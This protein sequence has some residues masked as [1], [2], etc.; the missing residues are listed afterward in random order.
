MA[1]DEPAQYPHDLGRAAISITFGDQAENGP[2]MQKL[3][4]PAPAGLA[5]EDLRRAQAAF[6]A[7]GARCEL[8]DLVAAGRVEEFGGDAGPEPAFLLV[9][10]GGVDAL[11]GPLGT[12]GLLSEQRSLPGRG[13]PP[14]MK[15]I[16]RGAVKTKRAR[17]NLCFWDSRQAPDYP[18]GKGRVVAFE[19]VPELARVRARLAEVFG[20][21]AAS[22]PAEGN[23]YFDPAKCGIGF[24]G[25]GERRIVVAVRLGAPVPLRYRWHLRCQPIGRPVEVALASGDMYAMSEKAVGRDWKKQ[26]VP[27]LRHAAGGPKFVGPSGQA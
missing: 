21:K 9:V 5:E 3:G 22:L 1:A 4:R 12:Q 15:A 13:M 17:H 16:F 27:T 11:L 20:P 18:S 23:Y 6:E 25:D 14:D 7:L 8:I 10:R 26:T 2:G 24:H 19:D